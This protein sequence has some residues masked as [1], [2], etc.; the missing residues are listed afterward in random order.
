MLMTVR[1]AFVNKACDAK[2]LTGRVRCDGSSCMFWRWSKDVSTEE[3]AS[4]DPG[5]LQNLVGFCGLACVPVS[6]G[7]LPKQG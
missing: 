6:K 4:T 5:L 1:T 7:V 2:P 3:L